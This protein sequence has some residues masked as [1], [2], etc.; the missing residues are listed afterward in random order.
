M[1]KNV[2]LVCF[3]M[4]LLAFTCPMIVNG[5]ETRGAIRGLVLDPNNSPVPGA[6][7]VVKDVARGTEVSATTNDEGFYQANYLLSGKYVITV[8]AAGF[9]TLQR[10]NIVIEIGNTLQV[11]LPLEI[12]GAAE[13]V[14]VTTD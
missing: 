8:E 4:L 11:D 12:G 9:K 14:T 5:Q 6:K 1:K 13:T 10:E 3:S 7:V 2:L